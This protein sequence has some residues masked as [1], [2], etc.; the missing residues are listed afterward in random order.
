MQAPDRQQATSWLP[1]QFFPSLWKHSDDGFVQICESEKMDPQLRRKHA[2]NI[3][4]CIGVQ[5]VLPSLRTY[6]LFWES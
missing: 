2:L 4:N 1:E 3:G 6:P 5:A